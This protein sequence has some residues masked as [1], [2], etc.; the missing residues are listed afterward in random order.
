MPNRQQGIKKA[1]RD[2]KE[3]RALSEAFLVNCGFRL[4]AVVADFRM[5]PR[6]RLLPGVL[7]WLYRLQHQMT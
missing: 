7:P 5:A 4:S 1:P 2:L 3:E 6:G